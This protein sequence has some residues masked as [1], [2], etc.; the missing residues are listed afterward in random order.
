MGEYVASGVIKLMIKED[1][2]IKN[3]NVLILGI[4]LKENCPDV[5]NTKLVDVINVL[6]DYGT[7]IT[8]YDPWAKKGGVK[9]E[10]GLKSSK[11]NLMRS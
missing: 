9:H 6:I 3:A 7:K 11:K 1:A 2:L 10:Y 5:R 4:T 8:I